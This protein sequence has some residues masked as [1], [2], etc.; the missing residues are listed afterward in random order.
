M[1]K[2]KEGIAA[3]EKYL[4]HSY[5][6]R[7][8]LAVIHWLREEWEAALQV[9]RECLGQSRAGSDRGAALG[10][11]EVCDVRASFIQAA[12]L[13]SSGKVE[14]A[15]QAYLAAATRAPGSRTPE[16]RGWTERLL[17]RG[18]MFMRKRAEP[19]V[20]TLSESLRCFLAWSDFWQKA[21][22][23]SGSGTSHLDI[24]RRQVWKAYTISSRPYCNTA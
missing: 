10:W 21:P 7:V 5:V 11:L 2:L 15:R 16:L 12:A 8:C 13:E 3:E 23:P 14:E 20:Q 4:E 9:L 1:P 22:P 6:T 24:P 17:A 18:C 19:T